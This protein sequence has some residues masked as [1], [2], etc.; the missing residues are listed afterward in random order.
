MTT[1][2]IRTKGP[3][4]ATATA[5]AYTDP[6]KPDHAPS[7]VTTGGV[8]TTFTYDANGNMLTGLAGK[9]MTYD[10]ENRPL[11]V[12]HLGKRTRLM[13]TAPTASA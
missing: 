1:S 11:S 13:S 3:T 12:T 10:G 5:Y 8:T 9:I 2:R 4:A 6:L 7:A